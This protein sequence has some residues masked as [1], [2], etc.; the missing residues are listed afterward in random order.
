MF[1]SRMTALVS[2]RRTGIHPVTATNATVPQLARQ[3]SGDEASRS[4]RAKALTCK[5][6]SSA[7]IS[8]V[9]I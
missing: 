6:N 9:H 4:P 1:S 2:T 3:S 8:R 5:I 7:T